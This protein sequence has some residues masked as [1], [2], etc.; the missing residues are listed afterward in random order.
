MN[1][2]SRRLCWVMMAV[3]SALFVGCTPQTDTGSVPTP[4]MGASSGGIAA[5]PEVDLTDDVWCPALPVGA[6]EPMPSFEGAYTSEFQSG[7]IRACSAL[8]RQVLADGVVTSAEMS[9]MNSAFTQCLTNVGFTQ[10]TILDSGAYS[11]V[12]PPA[13]RDDSEAVA[14]LDAQCQA[15]TDWMRITILYHEVIGNPDHAD[16]ATIMAQCLIRVGL[17]PQGYTAEE[18]MSDL[19]AN[20]FLSM[21]MSDEDNVKFD[22]CNKDPAHAK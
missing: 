3:G 20:V 15:T 12:S 17:R 7:Y 13:L 4:A 9:E 19:S 11:D 10:V 1:G 2:R 22:A 5:N 16:T 6:N 14:R 18:Y 8:G 21:N